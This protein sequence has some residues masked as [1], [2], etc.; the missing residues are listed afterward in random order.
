V[1]YGPTPPP[2]DKESA[3]RR[4]WQTV[5]LEEESRAVAGERQVQLAEPQQRLV[6]T[7]TQAKNRVMKLLEESNLKVA[8]VVSDLPKPLVLRG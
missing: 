6:E 2:G 7:R 4:P 3:P 5:L 8:H 1:L